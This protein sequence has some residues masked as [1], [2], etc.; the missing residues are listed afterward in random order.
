V[1]LSE[2]LTTVSATL[3]F[4]SP[5]TSVINIL[6]EVQ[7]CLHKVQLCQH[8]SLHQKVSV[9]SH[10]SIFWSTEFLWKKVLFHPIEFGSCFLI[11]LKLIWKTTAVSRNTRVFEDIWC[12]GVMMWIW[13]IPQK[14]CVVDLVPSEAVFKSEAFEGNWIMRAV[15]SSID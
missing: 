15:T 10:N 4:S 14:S 8:F 1:V 7:F 6:F 2:K 13:T 9:N 12:Y 3:V 11:H 5:I